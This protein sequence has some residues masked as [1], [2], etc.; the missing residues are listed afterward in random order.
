MRT[1]KW[2]AATALLL[3]ATAASAG[4]RM[5]GFDQLASRSERIDL[6]GLSGWHK[7]QFRL[8]ESGPGG[9]Y[10]IL[11]QR[12]RG[13]GESARYGGSSF[14]L[15]GPGIDGS[16]AG[17]CSFEQV[18]AEDRFRAGR[19]KLTLTE[20]LV[21]L[22]YRCTFERNGETIGALDLYEVAPQ[23]APIQQARAG[24]ASFGDRQ[25]DLRSE[26]YFERGRLPGASP[27]GYRI[28]DRGAE[29]AAVDLNGGRKRLALPADPELREA[30][31][32]SSIALALFWDPGDGDD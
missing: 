25:L 15:A 30:T 21:P 23:G 20:R 26:H 13:D 11:S 16:Y 18:N 7:G 22:R 29:I 28:E 9:K 5:R 4:E 12:D 17:R 10:S 1:G 24:V 31:L 8:G 3:T 2:I 6:T 27:L 32:L 19:L 14:T